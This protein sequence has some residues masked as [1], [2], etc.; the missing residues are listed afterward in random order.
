MCEAHAFL[1][2]DGK[3]K[4]ILENVDLVELNNGEVR[5]ENIFGEQ[6]ILKARFKLYSNTERKIV[7][8]PVE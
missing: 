1:L 6:K 8:E 4:K 3:E 5:L 7:L 2:K